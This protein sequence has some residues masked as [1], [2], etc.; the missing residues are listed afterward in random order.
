MI[1][2]GGKLWGFLFQAALDMSCA[3]MACEA[4]A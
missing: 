2:V 3:K 1:F 4:Q